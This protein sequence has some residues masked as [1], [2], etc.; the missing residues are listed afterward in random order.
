MTT[1]VSCYY[2]LPNNKK[3]SIESYMF[4]I[5]N[6]LTHCDTPIVMFSDGPIADEMDRIRNAT[7]PTKWLLIR[8]PLEQ[9][10]F[11]SP[12]YMSY[13]N[14]V[15]TIT[16]PDVFKIWV[17]KAFLT[18]E[19]AE[20]NPFNTSSFLWCDA[21]CWRDMRITTMYGPGWPRKQ[22]SALTMTWI[23]NSLRDIRKIICPVSLEDC[24]KEYSSAIVNKP[25]VAGAIFGGS[26]ECIQTLCD[27]FSKVLEICIKENIPIG[28]DQEILAF[29]AIWLQ[30][31]I[32]VAFYDKYTQPV[33][34]GTDEWFL[35]QTIL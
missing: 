20:Q 3:R 32:P 28:T 26:F 14:K 35:F 30:Q 12:E 16:P 7:F 34:E 21:G 25:S 13:F 23:D 24:V 18:K 27:V 29:S 31:I 2:L 33:P 5:F 11:S 4:W 17:N 19:I 22:V 9:L 10:K 6:F 15:S 8:R 1:I